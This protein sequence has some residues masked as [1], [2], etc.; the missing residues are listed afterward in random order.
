MNKENENIEK[1][2]PEQREKEEGFLLSRSNAV[3]IRVESI[4]SE[5]SLKI[6]PSRNLICQFCSVNLISPEGSL[7]H[8]C[9]GLIENEC[10]LL[11]EENERLRNENTLL[12]MIIALL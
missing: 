6:T 2:E 9:R 10:K 8:R 4:E 7:P 1:K 12:N 11:R 5:S 3:G